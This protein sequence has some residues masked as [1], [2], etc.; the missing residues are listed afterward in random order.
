MTLPE[1]AELGTEI[2]YEDMPSKTFIVNKELNRITG[3]GEGLLA[4]RQALDII[5]DSERFLW[6]IYGSDFG[7][8]LNSLIGKEYDYIV[9][10][11]PRRIK[12]AFSMDERIV[13]LE[14]FVYTK[15]GDSVIVSFD[16]ITVYG[17]IGREVE[18]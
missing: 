4:M 10:E 14:N 9:S 2:E 1:S 17:T 7:M 15:K 18:I 11:F 8:E 6:Q 12:E 5:L 3:T 13:R 16:V